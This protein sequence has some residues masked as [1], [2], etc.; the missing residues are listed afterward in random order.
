[1]PLH[2]NALV[3]GLVYHLLGEETGRQVHD[4]GFSAGKRRYRMFTFSRLRGRYVLQRAEGQ[5]QFPDGVT[6]LVS[7]PYRDFCEDVAQV[8]V[9]QDRVRLG[10]QWLRVHTVSLTSPAV[11]G[12]EAVFRTL[13]P[14][15]V[16][17]TV[18]RPDGTRFTYYFEPGSRE[19][20]R[21]LSQN[22][23]RKF[24]AFTGMP[25]RGEGVEF[26]WVGRSDLSVVRYRGGII[27]GY[28]GCLR[29]RGDLA[30][31]QLGLEAGLGAKNAQGFGMVEVVW[32]GGSD[33][34]DRGANSPWK[35]VARG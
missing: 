2:Y 22:L 26:Q 29:G 31:L 27:K 15:T 32:K 10:T 18:S 28:M 35:G 30:L 13:S 1:M 19:F 7:S 34:A 33:D 23:L 11:P 8:V 17:S 5:I 9:R 25:Y 12:S 16:Y 4:E 14:V 3:Q 20:A 21:L 6:L 24:E